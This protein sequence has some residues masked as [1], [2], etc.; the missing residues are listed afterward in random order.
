MKVIG[1]ILVSAAIQIVTDHVFGVAWP[2]SPLK[3]IAAVVIYLL[4]GALIWHF[5]VDPV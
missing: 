3:H 2:A 1:A 4:C 5:A